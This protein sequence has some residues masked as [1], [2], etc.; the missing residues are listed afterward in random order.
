MDLAVEF[1]KLKEGQEYILQML[2][3]SRN[4]KSELKVYSLNDLAKFFGVTTRTIYNWK[5][6]GRLPLT[7]VGSKSYMTE[8][9]LQEFLSKN[10]VKPF[11][12]GRI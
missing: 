11:N 7:I 2:Q 4:A 10:E 3:E 1:Q 12:S 8:E 5:D 9:Q 6:E